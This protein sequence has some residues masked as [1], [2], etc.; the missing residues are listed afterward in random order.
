MFED[1]IND[2]PMASDDVRHVQFTQPSDC[3]CFAIFSPA[4]PGCE[5]LD[6]DS[7]TS[8]RHARLARG[9]SRTVGPIAGPAVGATVG[10][11][12]SAPFWPYC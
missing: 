11:P 12:V 5:T 7:Q 4:M 3:R 1:K 6:L 10:P 8:A 9:A 2:S